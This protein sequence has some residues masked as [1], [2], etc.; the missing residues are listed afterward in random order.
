MVRSKKQPQ[1]MRDDQADKSNEPTAGYRS[2]SQKRANRNNGSLM[3]LDR[4]PQVLRVFLPERQGVQA[5]GQR[6]RQPA[7]EGNEERDGAHL[8]PTP[9]GDA[10]Q[11]PG[12][13]ERGVEL[14]AIIHNQQ[15]RRRVAQDDADRKPRQEKRHNWRSACNSR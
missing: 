10:P 5:S 11:Q 2:S 6:K 15:K 7:P 9:N 14:Q 8:R 3:K 1:E 12:I 13:N 4:N